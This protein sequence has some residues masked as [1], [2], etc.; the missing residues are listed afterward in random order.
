MR[1]RFRVVLDGEV[2]EIEIE[3]EEGAG[4]LEAFLQA[5]KTGVVKRVSAEVQAAEPLKGAVPAPITG[6]VVRVNVRSGERV[7]H[8]TVVAILEAM[9]TRV[10]VRAGRSGVV[11]SVLV[12]EGDVVKQ[13]QPLLVIE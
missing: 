6:R 10:E 2:Y 4:D 13:G 1:K 9:K 3:V 7:E 8:G 12:K 11:R 5:F